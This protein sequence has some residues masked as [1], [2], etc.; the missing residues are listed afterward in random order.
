MEH[1]VTKERI[2]QAGL[3]GNGEGA[4]V[5]GSKIR[6]EL[7]GSQFLDRQEAGGT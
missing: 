1:V 6:A 7:S 5:R 2:G 4:R 3:G